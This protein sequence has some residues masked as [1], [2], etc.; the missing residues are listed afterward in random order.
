[1]DPLALH[2]HSVVIHW[3]LVPPEVFSRLILPHIFS[4]LIP[5]VSSLKSCSPS[6]FTVTSS[7]ALSSGFMASLFLWIVFL[8][9]QTLG[10]DTFFDFLWTFSHLFYLICSYNFS[11]S[12]VPGALQKSTF[13]PD[14]PLP[15]PNVRCHLWPFLLNVSF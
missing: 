10:V 5:S 1:M 13:L 14:F 6:T 7:W 3:L 2:Q 15:S 8:L 11:C 9:L 4:T 12:F